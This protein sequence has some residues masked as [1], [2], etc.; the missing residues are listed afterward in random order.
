VTTVEH[1]DH[2][3]LHWQP[4]A[5]TAREA[6][7]DTLD[8]FLAGQLPVCKPD[9]PA[10]VAYDCPGCGHPGELFRRHYRYG[11]GGID[12]CPNCGWEEPPF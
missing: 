12:Y 5:A 11:P 3:G 7:F 6:L 1:T 10:R 9:E 4:L 8:A 2:A